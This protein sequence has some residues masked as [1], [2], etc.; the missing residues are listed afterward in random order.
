MSGKTTTT[1]TT[2]TIGTLRTTHAGSSGTGS[3]VA[4]PPSG[5][6]FPPFIVLIPPLPKAPGALGAAADGEVE[7]SSTSVAWAYAHQSRTTQ[8]ANRTSTPGRVVF[9][10]SVSKIPD[11]KRASSLLLLFDTDSFEGA[12]HLNNPK[13]RYLHSAPHETSTGSL[14]VL[15]KAWA[16]HYLMLSS[17]GSVRSPTPPTATTTNSYKYGPSES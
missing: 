13:A 8:N 15:W 4:P 12:R 9:Y 14:L 6:P 16:Q 11:D 3:S 2:G 7:M 5:T 10:M 1:D 17:I